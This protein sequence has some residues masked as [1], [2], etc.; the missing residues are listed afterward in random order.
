LAH[1]SLTALASGYNDQYL[2]RMVLEG[3]IQAL[4]FAES[5]MISRRSLQAFVDHAIAK[6]AADRRYGPKKSR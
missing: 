5:L 3:R 4:K 2:R 6:R 1:L